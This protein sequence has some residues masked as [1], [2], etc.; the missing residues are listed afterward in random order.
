MAAQDTDL[1]LVQRGNQPFRETIANISTKIREDLDVTLNGDIPIASAAQLGVIR[2]GTNLDIDANGI[3][4]AVLPAGLE[5]RGTWDQAGTVPASPDNGHFYIWDGADG[6]VL[7]NALWGTA[8]GET[9][10]EGD[11]LFYDGT[12]WEIIGN[13]GGGLT[14]ITGTAPIVVSAVADG[15]QDVS[16]TQADG[17]NDGYITSA[18]WNKLDGIEPGAQV[19]VDPTAGWATTATAGTLTLQPGGDTTGIPVATTTDAGLM[20]A[21]DKVTLD[22]LVATPGGVLSV[23]AG[24]GITNSGTA[25]APILDV[26]FGALPNGDPAT[27]T[28]MPYD[29]SSLG[30]LP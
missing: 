4:S 21:A 17:S 11:R 23:T 6:A 20:S 28:V 9:V 8:N 14:G 13:G 27:A 1:M 12:N 25:A 19:N 3:L 15:E 10:N 24:N 2:V 22:G 26:D 16:I 30:D 5:Y 7:A 18:D 29:I